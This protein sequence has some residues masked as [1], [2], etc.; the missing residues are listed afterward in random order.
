MD[1]ITKGI[2][3]FHYRQRLRNLCIFCT[4]LSFT[5][6]F[7][8]NKYLYVPDETIKFHLNIEQRCVKLKI[9]SNDGRR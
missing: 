7:T 1:N 9:F 8:E 3:K 5:L 6:Q 2:E 4:H